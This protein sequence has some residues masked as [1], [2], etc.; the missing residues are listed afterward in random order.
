[1]TIKNLKKENGFA[2]AD[3]LIAILI[4]TLFTGII[5]S[6]LYNI[7]LSNSSLK[8]MSKANGYIVDVFEYIDK[9]YYDKVSQK[10]LISYF[11]KKYYYQKDG[12]TPNEDAEV[13]AEKD[14]D[15]LV[16][17]YGDTPFK[18]I[19]DLKSYSDIEGNSDTEELDL[20]KE[21]TM[22]VKYRLGNKDQE[23]T[24]KRIKSREK[25]VSINKPDI[26]LLNLEQGQNAYS[27]KEINNNYVVCYENDSNWYN[28]ENEEFAKVL[29]TNKT[30][31]IGYQLTDEDTLIYEWIPRYAEDSEGNIKYLYSNTNKYVAEQ[32]GYQELIDLEDGYTVNSSF[33]NSTG[34]ETI[35]LVGS[36]QEIE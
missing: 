26:D 30:L 13:V 23:I 9:I 4:I 28:Y 34:E 33:I 24:V 5:A 31:E 15:A 22:T 12:I 17:K 35:Q 32:D 11:N 18:V 14:E 8:R 25:L 6:L 36:W 21:I 27:I 10:E 1:M 29:I 16:E 2:G 20:V 19:I 3:A 7:Y